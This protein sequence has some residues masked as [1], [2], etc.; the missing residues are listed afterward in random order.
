MFKRFSN[1]IL[2]RLK[3]TTYFAG[4][5]GLPGRHICSSRIEIYIYLGE[6]FY[7]GCLLF[8]GRGWLFSSERTTY[9]CTCLSTQ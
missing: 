7:V 2:A 8:G 4:L 3:F 6:G 9:S 1:Y 5:S